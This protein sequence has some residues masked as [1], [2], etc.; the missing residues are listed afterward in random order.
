MAKKSTSKKPGKAKA[1][2][3]PAA[4]VRLT[5]K[6]I[7]TL[8]N[9]LHGTSH[10]VY[11]L[12]AS[13]FPHATFMSDLNGPPDVA[14]VPPG[15]KDDWERLKTIG[16]VFKCEHCDEW[17]TVDQRDGDYSGDTCKSCAESFDELGEDDEEDEDEEEMETCDGCGNS[18]TS[19]EV[20][21]DGLCDECAAEAGDDSDDEDFDELD[22]GADDS[23]QD[24]EDDMGDDY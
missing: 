20:N 5:D 7:D 21:A 2:A 15:E 9:K 19:D 6:E 23:G 12:A 14:T 18:V 4:N 17:Q 24:D 3:E 10:N 13:M 16:K 1:E 8:A 11:E 22:D